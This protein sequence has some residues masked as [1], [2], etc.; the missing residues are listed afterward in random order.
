MTEIRVRDACA[1]DLTF[2]YDLGRSEPGFEV[3]PRDCFYPRSMIRDWLRRRGC[4]LLLVAETDDELRGFLMCCVGRKGAT[5]ENIV[6]DPAHR[7]RGIGT[8]LLDECFARLRDIP[9]IAVNALVRSGNPALG[10]FLRHGFGAG[11]EFTWMRA[12]PSARPLGRGRTL[13][14]PGCGGHRAL[15][16][17]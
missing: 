3:A 4:D 16:V 9:D 14:G 8:A 15:E 6:V 1:D 11:N 17:H 2:I 13:A 10:F 7:H 5:I 12:S